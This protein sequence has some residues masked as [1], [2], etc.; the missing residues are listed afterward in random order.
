M[1]LDKDRLYAAVNYVVQSTA[2]DVIAE[3]I[4]DIFDAG[5][6]DHLMM[7]IHDEVLFQAPVAD[8][9]EVGREIGKIMSK[10]FMGV[11]LTAS[12]DIYGK[13]WGGGYGA[14][15]EEGSW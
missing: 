15:K 14:N 4:V 7:P 3:S 6:G 11:P 2:R 9:E 1:P 10:P 5:L 8:A 12:A 13:N